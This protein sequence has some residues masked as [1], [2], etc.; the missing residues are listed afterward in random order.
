MRNR[1]PALVIAVTVSSAPALGVGLDTHGT[2]DPN[3]PPPTPVVTCQIL[4]NDITVTS[5]ADIYGYQFRGS[6]TASFPGT[7]IPSTNAAMYEGGGSWNSNNG[8]VNEWISGRGGNGQ[9]WEIH[10]GGNCK[11]DPWMTGSASASCNTLISSVIGNAPD[12]LLKSIKVPISASVMDAQA[13]SWLTGKTLAAIELEH[14]PPMIDEPKNGAI[15]KF[16]SNLVIIPYIGAGA[17]TYAVEWHALVN[18]A[19]AP[20]QVFS[21]A[22]L[23]TPLPANKFGASEVWQVRARAH[24]SVNAGWSPWVQFSVPPKIKFPIG[25]PPCMNST[26]YGATYDVSGMP[27]TIKAGTATKVSLK[28]TNGSNQ[29]WAA[30]SNFHL[31]YHWV[32]NGAV[33][34]QD[35][36]RTNMPSAIQPCGVIVLSATVKAPPAAGAYQ[37]Q[38]DMVLEGVAWFSNQG[39]MT[40]NKPVTVTP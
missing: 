14:K 27:A 30:G 3:A 9:A 2:A 40:G 12:K 18:G 7:G 32:Q 33:V 4:Q 20:Q 38:W 15:V 23:K 29:V 36:E 34:V 17:N 19:W 13:R 37:I 25:N 1:L 22:G 16:P 24:Q 39:V 31:S 28:V 8:M 5:F 26:A 21:E 11:L 6:C 10:G 35:G